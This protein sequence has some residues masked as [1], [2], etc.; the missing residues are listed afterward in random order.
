MHSLAKVQTASNWKWHHPWH[1]SLFALVVLII[2]RSLASDRFDK[3]A[4]HR[5]VVI[6]R[7]V[8]KCQYVL[9]RGV[10]WKNTKG[11]FDREENERAVCF[12]GNVLFVDGLI[13]IQLFVGPTLSRRS[14]RDTTK[15]K[16]IRSIVDRELLQTNDLLRE[17]CEGVP[18]ERRELFLIIRS[19]HTDKL[20]WGLLSSFYLRCRRCFSLNRWNQLHKIGRPIRWAADE[21]LSAVM[22][23]LSSL[24]SKTIAPSSPIRGIFI[25]TLA[26]IDESLCSVHL[27]ISL[28]ETTDRV[29]KTQLHH[30]GFF[31]TSDLPWALTNPAT[32]HNRLSLSVTRLPYPSG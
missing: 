27:F 3:S 24:I 21:L 25:D 20:S 30:D 23:L 15:N 22:E 8:W 16:W 11:S 29:D 17:E 6:V 28:C 31:R 7:L 13:F 32:E 1:A 14:A 18:M 10:N 12:I 4:P 9:W 5:C 2:S 19:F 26:K